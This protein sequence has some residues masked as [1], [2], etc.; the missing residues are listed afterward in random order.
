MVEEK[1]ECTSWLAAAEQEAVAANHRAALD[2]WSFITGRR[3]GAKPGRAKLFLASC[4]SPDFKSLH[5]KQNP[6]LDE[7]DLLSSSL[8]VELRGY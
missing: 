5:S 2:A 4:L 8:R 7:R 3:G 1:R 6:G